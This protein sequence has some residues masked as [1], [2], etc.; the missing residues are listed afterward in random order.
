MALV[1]HL[2]R[3]LGFRRHGAHGS[4]LGDVMTDRFLAINIL[5]ELH[6]DHGRQGMLMIGRGNEHGVDFLADL[7]KHSAV[8]GEGLDFRGIDSFALHPF[9]HR[10][11]TVLIDVHHGDNILVE[12]GGE[13]RRNAPAAATDLHAANLFAS[14]GRVENIK[15]GGGKHTRGESGSL[16]ERAAS[17]IILHGVSSGLTNGKLRNGIRKEKTECPPDGN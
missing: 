3:D 1:A 5:A 7:V 12:S 17:Q 11:M 2:R 13:V 6:G 15:R 4:S 9:F 14:I 16:H 8:I 10:E